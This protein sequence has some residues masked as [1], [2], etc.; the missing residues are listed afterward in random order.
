[1]LSASLN[2]TFLSLI[3]LACHVL[4]LDDW[5]ELADALVSVQTFA[6]GKPVTYSVFFFLFFLGGHGG[7]PLSGG[8][9][10]KRKASQ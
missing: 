2:K 6:G 8:G 10:G 1:M 3:I 9:G 5:E 4:H 7:R